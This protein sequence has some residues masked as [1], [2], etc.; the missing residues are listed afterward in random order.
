MVLE[1]DLM[2]TRRNSGTEEGCVGAEQVCLPSIHFQYKVF[3]VWNAGD[4][5]SVFFH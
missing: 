4:E 5:V 2:L 1:D 3:I